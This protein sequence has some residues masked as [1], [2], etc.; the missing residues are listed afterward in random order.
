MLLCMDVDDIIHFSFATSSGLS[1]CI[2]RSYVEALTPNVIFAAE[3]LGD[4]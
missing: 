1:V 2:S 3:P 4:N